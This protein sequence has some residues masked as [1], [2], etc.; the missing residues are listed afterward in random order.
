MPD[1]PRMETS[2]GSA[3]RERRKSIMNCGVEKSE[4]IPSR[5]FCGIERNV[6]HFEQG[7]AV[8]GI[9]RSHGNA[10]AGAYLAEP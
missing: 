3:A 1:V 4:A 10:D 8:R 6:G 2:T 5:E 9:A 7:F